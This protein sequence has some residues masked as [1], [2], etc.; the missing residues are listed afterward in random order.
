MYFINTQDY[1]NLFLIL[2]G[3]IHAKC[4][5]VIFKTLENPNPN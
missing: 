3:G 4:F 2:K 1:S 5:L